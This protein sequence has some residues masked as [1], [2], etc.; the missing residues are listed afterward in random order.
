MIGF[1]MLMAC[2]GTPEAPPAVVAPVESAPVLAWSRAESGARYA[3]GE[4]E[5]LTV[6]C[7][8]DAQTLGVRWSD[9][10]S[11]RL[12]I[13]TPFGVGAVLPRGS[14]PI[15][16]RV[17]PALLVS[18]T[19]AV[20][21]PGVERQQIPVSDALRE[22]LASCGVVR[23]TESELR[24]GRHAVTTPF[25]PD[26]CQATGDASTSV[27]PGLGETKVFVK[28]GPNGRFDVDL[29][30]SNGRFQSPEGARVVGRTLEWRLSN[31]RPV[32][33][34][35]RYEGPQETVIAVVRVA[36]EAAGCLIE[37]IEG[38]GDAELEGARSIADDQAADFDCG[39]VE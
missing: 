18:E 23:V 36:A 12:R 32:A 35:V 28:G 31:E 21:S 10:R 20:S 26:A 33:A 14:R 25:D 30:R 13:E 9:S 38:D 1:V 19:F 11:P 7:D 22:E 3:E 24:Q 34:L 2:S 5:V 29:G 17:W 15:W 6:R 16:A 39:A 8:L 27:C 4:E 37:S